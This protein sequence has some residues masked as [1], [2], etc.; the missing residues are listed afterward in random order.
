MGFDA[1]GASKSGPITS[2]ASAQRLVQAGIGT[3]DDR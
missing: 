2:G 3:G 1:Q